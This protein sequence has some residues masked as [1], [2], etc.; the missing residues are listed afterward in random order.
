[1]V[2]IDALLSVACY[3]DALEAR[4]AIFLVRGEG[5]LHDEPKE[6]LR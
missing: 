2:A 5:R 1:M 4:H 3:A 6:R